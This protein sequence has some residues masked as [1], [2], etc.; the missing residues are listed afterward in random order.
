MRRQ[1]FG[2]SRESFTVTVL[3]EELYII[4]SPEDVLAV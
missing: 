3:G 2:N 1:N 4:I